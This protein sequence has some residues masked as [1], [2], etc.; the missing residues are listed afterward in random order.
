M[1][2]PR[3]RCAPITEVLTQKIG[4]KVVVASKNPVAMTGLRPILSDNQPQKQKPGVTSAS[5]IVTMICAGTWS[6]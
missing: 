1:L 5:A 4:K 6:T 2:D 3:S